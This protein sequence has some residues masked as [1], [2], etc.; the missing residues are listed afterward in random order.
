[1]RLIYRPTPAPADSGS[2][3]AGMHCFLPSCAII[4][5]A[6]RLPLPLSAEPS[7]WAPHFSSKTQATEI[8]SCGVIIMRKL[9]LSLAL[10]VLIL[11]TLSCRLS[12]STLGFSPSQLPDAQVG[13]SFEVRIVISGNSTP[14]NDF[15]IS[16]GQLPQ[17]LTLTYQR[18]DD[19]ATISGTPQ[20]TGQ[21]KFT[22]AANC[23]GTN[24]PG[25]SGQQAYT[26]VVK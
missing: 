6:F 17:G 24:R 20:Q 9:S 21:Y 16:D 22:I 2:A 18:N 14:L 12:G 26:L 13:Q 5:K 4:T 23:L 11:S 19:F 7:R 10:L 1:M 15:Y 3:A 25:Q 8:G